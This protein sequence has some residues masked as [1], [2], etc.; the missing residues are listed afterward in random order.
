MEGNNVHTYNSI[1][2]FC[3]GQI[4]FLASI[5]TSTIGLDLIFKYISIIS[6]VMVIVINWKKFISAIKNFRK[7]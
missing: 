5:F 6:V 2:L 3:F 1:T 7:K 4:S